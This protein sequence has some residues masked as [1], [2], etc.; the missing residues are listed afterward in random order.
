MKDSEWFFQI[1]TVKV[2]IWS[3]YE[4]ISNE[5]DGDMVERVRDRDVTSIPSESS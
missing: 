1:F 3:H 4:K 5:R 2:F